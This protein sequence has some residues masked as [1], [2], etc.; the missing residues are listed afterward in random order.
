MTTTTALVPL[1]QVADRIA[2]ELGE[3]AWHDE[4]RAYS[5][6]LDRDMDVVV[7]WAGDDS[8]S[9]ADAG[10]LLVEVVADIRQRKAERSRL[11][12]EFED[13]RA[14]RE[15]R[16]TQVG[17]DAYVKKF[18]ELKAEWLSQLGKGYADFRVEPFQGDINRLVPPNVRAAARAASLAA[19]E[20]FDSKQGAPLEFSDWL[21][22]SPRKRP[23]E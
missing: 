11:K 23:T 15:E 7:N 16:R 4:K 22:L 19:R 5:A 8:V 3:A 20:E 17:N 1:K 18:E 12:A 13:Y 21:A 2:K 10:R 9:E 6:A 14:A